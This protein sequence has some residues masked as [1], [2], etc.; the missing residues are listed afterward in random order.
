MAQQR[1]LDDPGVNVVAAADDEVLGPADQV[2]EAVGVH[3]AEVAG[4]QPAVT[5]DPVPAHPGAAQSR[6]GD[7]PGEHGGAADHQL[8]GLAGGAVG[9]RPVVGYPD[10]FDLLPGQ[11]TADR[12]GPFLARPGPGAGAGG[13]GEAVAFQQAPPGVLC[14]VLAH[15]GRQRGRAHDRQPQRAD[16]GV[17][18]DLRQ[19]AVD[20]GDGGHRRDLVVLDDL[21]EPGVQGLVTVTGRA[22]P[23]HPGAAEHRGDAGDD[24]GVD[25]E[26]REPAQHS[27]AGGQPAG[28]GDPPAAGQ[29]VGVGM[30]GD[31]R[32]AGGPPG[33][34]EGGQVVC[35][36]QVRAGQVADRL[37]GDHV[38]EIGHERPA[39][40]RVTAGRSVT[41]DAQGGRV[42][43]GV[44]GS[45]REDGGHPR[46]AGHLEQPL[47]Q[48]RVQLGAGRDQD[49]GSG[50]ADQLGDPLAGRRGVDRGGDPDGLRGQRGGVQH[51][52]V[53]AGQRD[54]VLAPHSQ[55]GQR[56][57]DPGHHAG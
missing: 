38:V 52:G 26:Q 3:A 11:D 22:R 12:S 43:V 25:V 35:G 45:Q 32:G 31:L 6:V 17:D 18:R 19:R 4:I 40:V 42:A 5:D 50:P 16:I 8:A 34:H 14:E 57:G 46:L 54:R 24:Q 30:R 9:P 37:P 13:L 53:D 39:A 29:L 56:V 10:G 33:V 44:V 7:V 41:G 51:R 23:H 15:R 36:R 47:P 2:H 55:G 28:Q 27:P 1:V 20:G 49:P 21:P 48:L